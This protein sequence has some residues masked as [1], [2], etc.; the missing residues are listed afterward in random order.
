MGYQIEKPQ[1]KIVFGT[2]FLDIE[3]LKN[4]FSNYEFSKLKQIHSDVIIQTQNDCPADAHWTSQLNLGL[5]IQT[6]DCLPVMIYDSY[7]SKIC[8]IHA[9]WRGIAQRILPKSIESIYTSKS[10]LEIFIGPCIHKESFE[11]DKDVF[12]QLSKSA[13]NAE[14]CGFF[15]PQRNKY[16]FDLIAVA[17]LQIQET[18]IPFSLELLSHDTMKTP[19]FSSFRREKRPCRN[20]SFILK[21]K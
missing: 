1:Y 4:Y 5:L 15:N 6:A 13:K 18:Q 20:W 21:S 8:A 16:H 11:I 3:T 2:K 10:K 17:H 7:S 14:R 9:G 19:S 12:D